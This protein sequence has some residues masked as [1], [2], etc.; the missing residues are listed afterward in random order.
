MSIPYYKKHKN[1]PLIG[2]VPP[3]FIN[4][5]KDNYL[6]LNDGYIKYLKKIKINILVIPYNLDK[7]TIEIYLKN[8]DGLFFSGARIGNYNQELEFI[9]Q[10]TTVDY[11]LQRAIELNK[12]GRVF[13][14]YASCHGIQSIIK[15][16]EKKIHEF[17]VFKRLDAVNF[18]TKLEFIQNDSNNI[19]K[20]AKFNN[21]IA[22]H[23]CTFGITPV[24][25]NKTKYLKNEYNII[26]IGRDRRNK[27]FVDFIKHKVHPIYA[28]QC[29]PE[30]SITGLLDEYIET[31]YKSSNIRKRR[32]IST[33]NFKPVKLTYKSKLCRKLHPK[34]I[35]VHI[36]TLKHR[37]RK[38]TKCH[39]VNI[40]NIKK[41]KKEK[42][43]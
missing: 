3:P 19:N 14:V 28:F 27:K 22:L 40:T 25:F 37:T 18:K 2:V 16:A 29:H 41:I 23:N 9:Q 20:Y 17:N 43:L 35:N 7:K 15:T 8:I 6:Y 36:N 31:I 10:Y 42:V 4:D 13:P 24:M 33:K 5:E 26:A 11:L 21:Q 30:K 12:S 32:N 34:V 39:I 1:K 38:N